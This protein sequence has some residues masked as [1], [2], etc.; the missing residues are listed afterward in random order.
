VGRRHLYRD[1]AAGAAE[2]SGREA[3]AAC[4]HRRYVT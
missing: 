4:A 3:V 2:E 1:A